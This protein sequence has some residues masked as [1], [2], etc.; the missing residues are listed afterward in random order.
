MHHFL[1]LLHCY[2]LSLTHLIEL[3]N[4]RSKLS[5]LF[6]LNDCYAIKRNVELIGNGLDFFVISEQSNLGY[7]VIG[8][9]PC[10]LYG[11]LFS[12]LRQEYV[13]LVCPCFFFNSCDD[14]HCTLQCRC[15]A[16]V[17]IA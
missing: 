2:A 14:R 17:I 1:S 15:I 13:F 9:E 3:L 12:T 11:S 8:D 6:R 10:S 4:K 7:S 5:G 16:T